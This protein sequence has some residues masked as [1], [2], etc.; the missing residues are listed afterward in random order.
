MNVPALAARV[1]LAMLRWAG[2]RARGSGAAR[3]A[4]ATALKRGKVLILD[5]PAR[6]F[7]P[8]NPKYAAL[9]LHACVAVDARAPAVAAAMLH[10]R[11]RGAPMCA[12]VPTLSSCAAHNMLC[13]SAWW[14]TGG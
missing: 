3:S 14:R 1:V 4:G 5:D 2:R 13:V 9:S 8:N 12:H 11:Q 6:Q 7:T 10:R